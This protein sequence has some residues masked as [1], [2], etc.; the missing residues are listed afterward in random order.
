M[1]GIWVGW[2]NIPAMLVAAVAS[3]VIANERWNQG[4]GVATMA[5]TAAA[6]VATSQC[7]WILFLIL[8]FVLC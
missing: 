5:P 6:L 7:I 2:I 4:H 8:F 1:R 3:V